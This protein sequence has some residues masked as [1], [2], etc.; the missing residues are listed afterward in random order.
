MKKAIM[1]LAAA[2]ISAAAAVT[3]FAGTG[4][5]LQNDYGYWW[6]RTDGSYPVSEWKWIDG[7]GDGIAECYHFDA[8]GYLDMGTTV[9][10]YY[11]DADG[12]WSSGSQKYTKTGEAD[13]ILGSAKAVETGSSG[14]QAASTEFP[15]IDTRLEGNYEMHTEMVDSL[16]HIENGRDGNPHLYFQMHGTHEDGSSAEQLYDFYLQD[17]GAGQSNTTH[18]YVADAVNH[19]GDMLTFEWM[20]GMNELQGVVLNGQYLT[21]YYRTN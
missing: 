4:M 15:P 12:A 21:S 10:G 20:P 6:Q 14:Q 17:V 13:E 2:V 16:I 18:H 7:N 1:V 5:W 11:V 3:A 8:K 19:S 9:E